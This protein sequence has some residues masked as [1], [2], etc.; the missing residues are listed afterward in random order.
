M[1]KLGKKSILSYSENERRLEDLPEE[2]RLFEW[3]IK[4]KSVGY[5]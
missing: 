4:Y 1:P 3:E 2:K 5:L